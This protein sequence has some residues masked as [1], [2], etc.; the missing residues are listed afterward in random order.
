MKCEVLY[1]PSYSLL[2]VDLERGESL[3]AEAGAMVSMSSTIEIETSMRSG[4]MGALKRRLL[5]KESFFVNTFTAREPGEVTL[6]PSVPGDIYA[7]D[8]AGRTL[9]AQSGAYVASS[10]Q[11]QIDTQWGGAKTFFSKQG[12]FLLKITGTGKVFLSSFGAVHEVDLKAA[13]KHVVDTGH[14]VAFTETVQYTVRRV[15]GLKSTLLSGEGLVCDLTGPGKVLI[16]S[17]SQD[18]FLSWLAPKVSAKG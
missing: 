8:L 2:K 7:I 3:S 6:A 15:G 10:P 5:T 9:Y 13:E 1:R 4:L 17:R 18:A 14:M 12:L 16:Q 11:I